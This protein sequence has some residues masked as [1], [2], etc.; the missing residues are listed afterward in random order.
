VRLALRTQRTAD[1]DLA[2]FTTRA[3]TIYSRRGR[4]GLSIRGPGRTDA[5]VVRNRSRRTRVFYAAVYSPTTAARRLD[6]P[7]RLTVT[8]LR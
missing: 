6:A 2:A 3:R 4:V 8:R 1:P 5:L 7:Y